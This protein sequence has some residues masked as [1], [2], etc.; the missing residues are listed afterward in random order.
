MALMQIRFAKL[1]FLGLDFRNLD[2]ALFGQP[3]CIHIVDFI[4]H[5]GIQ[6]AFNDSRRQ[7]AGVDLGNLTI[8]E[9]L[10]LLYWTFSQCHYRAAEALSQR[11]IRGND[12]HDS[13]G[14]RRHIDR[15]GYGLTL[16][17]SQD[18]FGDIQRYADLGLNSRGTKMRVRTMPGTPTSG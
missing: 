13:R 3:R 7:H 6:H 9:N 8:I 1:D 5:D 4:F 18:A 16:Q 14:N 11:Q 17:R 12:F 15:R 2:A 10:D